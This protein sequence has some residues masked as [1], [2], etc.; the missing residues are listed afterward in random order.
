MY[1]TQTLTNQIEPKVKEEVEHKQPGVRVRDG[2]FQQHLY[3]ASK[4]GEETH[5]KCT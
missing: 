2:Q 1:M 5:N 4:N 3:I